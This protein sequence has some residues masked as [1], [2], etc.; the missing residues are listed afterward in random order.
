ML[1]EGLHRDGRRQ[2]HLIQIHQH[3]RITHQHFDAFVRFLGAKA[4]K[5][6]KATTKIQSFLCARLFNNES[7]WGVFR[8]S[9]RSSVRL[10]SEVLA[11]C[12]RGALVEPKLIQQHEGCGGVLSAAS[13]E[14][15]H[16][17]DLPSAY[18]AEQ[19]VMANLRPE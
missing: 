7:R 13:R 9:P 10:E 19:V 14:G 11:Q 12:L 6:C 3:L 17:M 4:K 16:L 18:R 8:A 15:L 5:S 2:L 1:R